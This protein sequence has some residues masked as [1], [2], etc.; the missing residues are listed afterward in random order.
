MEALCHP[1]VLWRDF[2]PISWDGE[3]EAEALGQTQSGLGSLQLHNPGHLPRKDF[4]GLPISHLTPWV[5]QDGQERWDALWGNKA[6][7]TGSKVTTWEK[8]RVQGS[9]APSSET[10]TK[11]RQQRGSGC[12]YSW[13]LG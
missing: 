9:C 8:G 1:A 13:G 10:Q 5:H 12:L 7:A 4:Q 11:F 6:A 3:Q 2:L